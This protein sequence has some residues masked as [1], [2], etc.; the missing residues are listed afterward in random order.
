[1]EFPTPYS[2]FSSYPGIIF[3]ITGLEDEDPKTGKVITW[4]YGTPN[5][6]SVKIEGYK[7]IVPGTM[8]KFEMKG[9]RNPST[10]GTGYYYKV[11]IYEK[12]PSGSFFATEYKA[13]AAASL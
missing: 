1:M 8:I 4:Q 6:R 12:V 2:A 7:A 3:N 11:Y 5:S 13:I 9:I 10:M